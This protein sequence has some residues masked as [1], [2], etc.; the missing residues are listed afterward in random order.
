MRKFISAAVGVGLAAGLLAVVPAGAADHLDAPLVKNDGRTDINDVYVY[1]SPRNDGKV[2]LTMTVNPVAGVQSPETFAPGV[3]YV[4]EIDTNGDA[5]ADRRIGI[6]FT[7]ADRAGRQR[8]IVLGPDFGAVGTTG[9]DVA[10]R[11]YAT[12]KQVGRARADLHDDPFFFDLAAFRNGLAF[13]PGGVGTNFFTGLNVT[14]ITLEIPKTAITDGDTTTGVWARTTDMSGNTIDRM[15]RPAINTVFNTTDADKD[16]FN[17]GYPVDDQANF[18]ANVVG[19]LLALGNDQATADGLADFLLPDIITIDL[20]QPSAFP[21]GRALSDDVIDTELNLITGGAV[22][23]D[24]V[25]ND[26]RFVNHFPYLGRPN[27]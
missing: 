5:V 27:R 26:N 13:C 11:D 8:Y 21:N 9:H 25:A 24:C 3:P 10:L 1:N 12:N 6:A 22:P 16:A 19:T 7:G 17:A 18:R 14:A 2:I 23:S 4:F 20:A 15:G